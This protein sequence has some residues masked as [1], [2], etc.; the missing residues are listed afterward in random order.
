MS[1]FG[2]AWLG[3]RGLG[4]SPVDNCSCVLGGKHEVKSSL[5]PGITSLVARDY[6]ILNALQGYCYG[7]LWQ[8]FW[9]EIES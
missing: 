4:S 9:I 5:L 1:A 3:R 8:M 7:L 2:V 6:V